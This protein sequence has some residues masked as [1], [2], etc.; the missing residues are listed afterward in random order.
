VV[1]V[2]VGAGSTYSEM[3]IVEEVYRMMHSGHRFYTVSPIDGTVSY[4]RAV[5]C[6][7]INTLATSPAGA[8][9]FDYL[10]YLDYLDNLGP[11]G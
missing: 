5:Y 2:G 11:C 4:I 6:C 8:D 1:S 3:Y 10:D 7:G 9:A